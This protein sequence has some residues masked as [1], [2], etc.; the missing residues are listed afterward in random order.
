MPG[1]GEFLF[2]PMAMA[3]A[4]SMI[5]AYLLSRTFV[6]ARC[7]RLAERACGCSSNP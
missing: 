1:L 5:A 2:K 7:A 3:V 6:P 4:F